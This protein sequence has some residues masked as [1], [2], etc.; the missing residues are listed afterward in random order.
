[1]NYP[2]QKVVTVGELRIG[3]CHGHQVVPWGDRSIKNAE[4]IIKNISYPSASE[5][6]YNLKFHN[7]LNTSYYV[8]EV[9]SVQKI[10]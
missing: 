10:F 3:L 5:Y 7:D 8:S 9:R 4:T 6:V 1:M 2:E